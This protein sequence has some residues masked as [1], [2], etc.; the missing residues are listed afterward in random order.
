[1]STFAAL[2]IAVVQSLASGTIVA[3]ATVAIADR[4][5]TAAM[6]HAVE[7]AGLGIIAAVFLCHLALEL[8]EPRMG[9]GGPVPRELVAS[10]ALVVGWAYGAAVVVLAARLG[11]GAR[12]VARLRRSAAPL[13]EAWARR[14]EALA[15]ELGL[16]RSIAAAESDRIDAPLVIG[17]FRPL[18][19]LPAGWVTALPPDVVEAV[20]VHEL[21]HVRRHDV[22]LGWVQ[23]GLEVLLCFH[24]A[25]WWL[26]RRARTSREHCCDDAAA[27]RCGRRRYAEALLRAEEA[28]SFGV[29]VVAGAC[30]VLP[31]A[32]RSGELRDRIARVLGRAALTPR[33]RWM[34]VGLLALLALGLSAPTPA[35]AGAIAIPWLPPRV[36][37]WETELVAAGQRHGVD[38]ELLAIVALVES[39]GNPEAKS[40]VGAHGLL[41]LMPATAGDVA[42]QRGLPEP[43]RAGLLEPDLN[44]D[45]GA[46]YLAQQLAAFEGV[47]E[48]AAAYNG[49]PTRVRSWLHGRAHLPEETEHYR[50]LVGALW[51]ERHDAWSPTFARLAAR[52]G[53]L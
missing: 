6:R 46:Y 36:R 7:L 50:R 26:S 19:L 13:P 4:C 32:R 16:A 30:G 18:V 42:R 38:P 24:P 9:A 45:F 27:A 22:L 20:L 40:P 2:G 34:A 43:T 10:W 39:G 21:W 41:Q 52:R 33:R 23:A 47:E 14:I 25:A 17:W 8:G 53:L 1:M 29:A 15:R 37:A 48:A 44:I 5:R 11:L 35:P 49:G 31:A 51:R 12:S 3:L 28:R